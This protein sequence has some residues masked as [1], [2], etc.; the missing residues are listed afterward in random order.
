MGQKHKQKIEKV[1]A[2]PIATDINTD[3]FLSALEHFGAKVEKTKTNRA[4]I[5]V[6][7]D[8]FVLPISHK[9]ILTKEEVTDLRHFLEKVGITPDKI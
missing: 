6:G 3:K 4:K 5:F 7:S 1:F 8:E 9:G 2:H